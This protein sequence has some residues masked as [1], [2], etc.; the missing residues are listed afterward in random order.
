M[1]EFEFR[2]GF[3][4]VLFCGSVVGMLYVFRSWGRLVSEAS[5]VFTGV[6]VFYCLV[7]SV[8]RVF[9]WKFSLFSLVEVR[10]WFSGGSVWVRF[11][12]FSDIFLGIIGD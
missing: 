5:L 6:V 1:G 7:V 12:V 10:G 2:L 4:E 9:L 8:S 3:S 11:F